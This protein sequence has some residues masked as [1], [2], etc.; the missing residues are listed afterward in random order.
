MHHRG[1]YFACPRVLTLRTRVPGLPVP[2]HD[3]LENGSERR[4]ADARS[5]HDR[6]LGTEYVTGRRSVRADQ[7]NLRT[8]DIRWNTRSE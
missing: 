6:V 1:R 3:R 4:D 8:T 2:V 7:I 5:D